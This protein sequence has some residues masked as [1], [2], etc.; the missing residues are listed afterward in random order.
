MADAPAPLEVAA[1]F[2]IYPYAGK[3]DLAAL[4]VFDIVVNA[5]K[6]DVVGY[7]QPE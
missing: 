4:A 6:G 2:Q 5:D 7:C 3:R 1:T